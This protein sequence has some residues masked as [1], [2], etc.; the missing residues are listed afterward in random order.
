MLGVPETGT[1][2]AGSCVAFCFGICARGR[3]A[4]AARRGPEELRG[5]A[6]PALERPA[7][8]ASGRD[9]RQRRSLKIN[10]NT[11]LFCVLLGPRL[12]AASWVVS[13]SYLSLPLTRPLLQLL[14]LRQLP[15]LLQLCPHDD[16]AGTGAHVSLE[17]AVNGKRRYSPQ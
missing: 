4:R 10:K 8:N 15:R 16:H 6:N 3:G 5:V 14:R 13:V 7:T 17:L 2:S 11:W 1:G 9:R 12:G